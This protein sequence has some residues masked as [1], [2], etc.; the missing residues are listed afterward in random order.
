MDLA[1]TMLTKSD[2][3]G[4]GKSPEAPSLNLPKALDPPSLDR[5]V[6]ALANRLS[7]RRRPVAFN[8]GGTVLSFHP[9]GLTSIAS[10]GEPGDLI[11]IGL[12]LDGKAATLHLRLG[13]FERIL[14]RVDPD[15]LAADLGD[16][17]MPLLLEAC[18]SDV[19]RIAEARYRGRIELLKIER[20]PSISEGGR[21]ILLELALDGDMAGLASLHIDESGAERLAGIL[22]EGPKLRLPYGHLGA[23]LS[24]RGGVMWLGLGEL[25]SLNVGDVLVPDEDPAQAKEIAGTLG[26]TWLLNAEF[27]KAGLTLTKPLRPATQKDRDLWMMVDTKPT[28]DGNSGPSEPYENGQAP[29][30]HSGPTENL[31]VPHGSEAQTEEAP[32]DHNEEASFD[33]VPI[34]LVFELGRLEISLGRL[35]ELGPGHVFEL[36]RPVGEAVEVFAGGRRVGQGEIVKVGE[37]VGVRMVRLFGHG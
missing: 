19:L 37:Q 20:N 23:A 2:P 36:D 18:F 11:G 15:L 3:S 34:K 12:R 14:E 5:R 31:D 9:A 17:F 7:V 26:E 30:D 24:F 4:E 6:V 28:Q 35:Q 13:L 8:M 1:E 25:R 10:E 29:A 21:S 16:D 33:Q 32:A 27:T 22:G